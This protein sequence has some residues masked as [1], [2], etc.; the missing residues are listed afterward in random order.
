MIEQ[1]DRMTIPTWVRGL[2]TRYRKH[3]VA[4][5]V[6]GLVGAGCATLLMFDAGY[7]I[8]RTAQQGITLFMVMIPVA[9]VQLFGLGRP[10][11]R[12]LERLVSHDWVFR[13]T[14]DLR[15]A[16]FKAISRRSDDPAAAKPLGEYLSLLA[17]DIGHLQNLYLRV[18]F[19]TV[20]ALA[21]WL[22]ATLF[23]GVFRPELAIALF[24]VGALSAL[25]LP[26]AALRWTQRD[27]L[28]AKDEKQDEY[29]HLTD[30]VLGSVDWSLAGRSDEAAQ[31]HA[32]A[33]ASLDQLE[34]RN[35]KR[36]R[37][38]ELCSSF[39]LAAG[40]CVM[41]CLAAN[42]FGGDVDN[43]GFIAAFALGFFPLVE[44]FVSLPSSLA[45]SANHGRAITRLDSMAADDIDKGLAD[46]AASAETDAVD[47]PTCAGLALTGINY[48][49]PGAQQPAL[50]DLNLTINAGQTVAVLGRSGAGKSTMAALMRGSLTPDEGTVVP[51][52][53]TGSAIQ[54]DIRNCVSYIPQNPHMFDRSLRQN[55]RLARPSATDDEL[56][57][58]LRAVGLKQKLDSLEHGLDTH[59]G[60]TGVGLSGG[61]AHRVALARALVANSP[62]IVL[63][64]PF[65]ALDPAT[66]RALLDTLFQAFAGK[67]LVVITHHLMGIERFDRAVFVQDGRVSLNGAPDV[68][69]QTEPAFQQ[70]IAFDRPTFE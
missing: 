48:R 65:A 36:L 13:V 41:L 21:L 4:A 67:T 3:A 38:V 39:V 35:R 26:I 46:K 22:A 2:L 55:L 58:A 25:V 14:S 7:L 51:I 44:V 10:I 1:N 42:A 37:L 50:A 64:E 68:L 59:M 9:L 15:Y 5:F 53:E 19:P 52:D 62:I 54:A 31:L 69:A 16:L 24:V 66:E 47:V 43:V 8:S 33:C 70:L 60:E 17:D 6:L 56:V 30:D 34:S 20:I 49:Y 61:E 11:A 45:D 27:T 23:C 40:A 12:Y 18:A 63:D 57:D 28:L 29:A 32:R